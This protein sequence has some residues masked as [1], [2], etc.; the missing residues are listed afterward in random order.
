MYS[1]HAALITMAYLADLLLFVPKYTRCK[2]DGTKRKKK[3]TWKGICVGI[4]FLVLVIET[5]LAGFSK[6][7][8]V[9][10][11]ILILAMA[12]CGVGDIYLEIKF[13]RG[14]KLF[15][16]GHVCYILSMILLTEE[17]NA[18]V[19]LVFALM[20]A[21]GTLLTVW[22]LSKKYRFYL[23]VYNIAISGT[24]AFS[25]PLIMTGKPALVLLGTGAC[26]LMVS[27]WLLARNK[28]YGNTFTW[29]LISL[30][31]YFGG[32]ILISAYPFLM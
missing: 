25:L 18:S 17:M 21:I 15:F 12:L 7:L 11:Y 9:S 30:L 2:F 22:K 31:F 24:F 8:T 6:E 29:S 23:I 20:I 16:F 1:F 5:I 3:L 13:V 32:Q 19:F 4:P 26:F 27:D 14:G 28:K 10:N